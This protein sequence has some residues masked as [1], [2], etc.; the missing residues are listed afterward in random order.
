MIGSGGHRGELFRPHARILRAC[1]TTPKK[2]ALEKVISAPLSGR[3]K[4]RLVFRW[5]ASLVG[6]Y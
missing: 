4:K 6:V 3:K 2:V 1:H 5:S